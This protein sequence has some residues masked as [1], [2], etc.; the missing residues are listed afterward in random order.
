MMYTKMYSKVLLK[1]LA[2]LFVATKISKQ[3]IGAKF[4]SKDDV[5]DLAIHFASQH[6]KAN[7]AGLHDLNQNV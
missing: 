6:H 2:L 5:I 3:S 1:Y 7:S 4:L